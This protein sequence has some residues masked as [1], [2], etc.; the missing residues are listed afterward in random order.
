VIRNTWFQFSPQQGPP[1]RCALAFV[2]ALTA[3][4]F[5]IFGS[6]ANA[7]PKSAKP[8]IQGKTKAG[9]AMV[10][11]PGDQASAVAPVRSHY[12]IVGRVPLPVGEAYRTPPPKVAVPP[13]PSKPTPYVPIMMY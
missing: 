3:G 8:K 4:S 9:R 10:P 6:D 12:Y 13:K 2:L 1:A 7:A 5:L 11:F